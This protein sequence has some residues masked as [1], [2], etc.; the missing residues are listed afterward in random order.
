[1]TSRLAG[2]PPSPWEGPY[3]F[4][5]VVRAGDFVLV[6]GTTSVD[7]NGVVLGT[8][9]YDQTVDILR[10]IE[11]ELA[12]AGAGLADVVQTRVYVTDISR[13]DDVGRAHGEIFSEIRP[14]MTMVE[15]SALID[16]RMLVEIETVALLSAAGAA[17]TASVRDDEPT[18]P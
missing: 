9:P 1:L 8:T 7:P 5:R 14:L 11:H 10:K 13:S 16:P 17:A 3:G 2:D 15:V 12:R 4:S 18:P 6:G